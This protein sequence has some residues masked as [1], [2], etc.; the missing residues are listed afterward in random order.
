VKKHLI[1]LEEAA[2]NESGFVFGELSSNADS[3]SDSE[4]D[5]RLALLEG[6]ILEPTIGVEHLGALKVSI[7]SHHFTE[8]SNHPT[9][10]EAMLVAAGGGKSHAGET[11]ASFNFVFVEREI[12][13]DMVDQRRR[14]HCPEAKLLIDASA[15]EG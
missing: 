11:H 5:E 4:R 6:W 13:C 15:E 12:V 2:N 8:H 7:I 1:A 14:S 9:L 10:R 3:W